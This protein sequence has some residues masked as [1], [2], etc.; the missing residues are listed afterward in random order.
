M[1]REI[2][3]EA[4]ELL[5]ELEKSKAPQEK[6]QRL[7][8]IFTPVFEKEREKEYKEKLEIEKY[9]WAN[10]IPHKNLQTTIHTLSSIITFHQE[11]KL[12][13]DKFHAKT[14]DLLHAFELID[15]SDEELIDLGKQLITLRKERRKTKNFLEL[16]EPL[17]NFATK[18]RNLVKE[19]GQIHGEMIKT[20][21]NFEARNYRVKETSNTSLQEAFEKAKVRQS[22]NLVTA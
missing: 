15:P 19:L 21:Q 4:E 22:N 9:S 14:Q 2:V 12:E 10:F 6:V 7:K 3:Y 5:A 20:L 13:E 1:E 18:N 16:T 11:A 17:F 8:E